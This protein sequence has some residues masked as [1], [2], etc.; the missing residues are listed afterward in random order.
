MLLAHFGVAVFVVGVTLVKGYEIERDVRMDVGETRRRS[1]ATRSASTAS[2]PVT[3][4]N[5][6]APRGTVDVRTRRPARR[7]AAPEK[8]VYTL[9][10][11]R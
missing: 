1:A 11:G 4:P 8:R 5:Y 6:A 2:T 9:R 10:A 7:D 3:G